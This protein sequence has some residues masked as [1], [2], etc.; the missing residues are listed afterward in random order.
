M[1]FETAKLD[2]FLRG[3][4]GLNGRMQIER[5]SGGQSNPTFFVTYPGTRLVVRKQ[6]AGE[7]LPSAHAVDRE[8]RVM[9]A[10]A[11]TDVPVPRVRLFNADRD[12][13]GTPFYVM[14]RLEGRVFNDA[15][16]PEVAPADRHAM[17]L[18][19]AEMLARLHDVDWQAAGLDGFGKPGR[20]YTRQIARWT[21]QWDAAKFRDIPDLAHLAAWLPDHLPTDETTTI[22]HGDYRVGNMI[23]HPTAPR[24]VGVLDWELSTL[25]D[26]LA[27]LAFSCLLWRST[28]D[29]YGGLLGLDLPALGIPPEVDYVA[30][31]FA[32]RR[33][34]G[35]ARLTPFHLAFACFRFAVIFEGIAARARAGTA[36]AA[37]AAEVGELSLAFARRGIES[38]GSTT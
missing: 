12:I 8:A 37:D 35:A 20:Y 9:Q 29:E 18:S 16:M 19:V 32:H 33:T 38:I 11:R 31:Y 4:L 10:L 3:A 14:D 34:A 5:I 7:V 27:D 1:E 23:F 26:P 25:G 36:A 15:A 22:A 13:V 21:R 24:V 30:H 28:R 17:Y 6:P 2:A